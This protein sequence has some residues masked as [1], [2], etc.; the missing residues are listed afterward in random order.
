[1][2]KFPLVLLIFLF[3]KAA[4]GIQ[5]SSNPSLSPSHRPSLRPSSQPSCNPS[6]SPSCEPTPQPTSSPS[7]SPTSQPPSQPSRNPSL[8][9]SS[10][11][12]LSAQQSLSAQPSSQPSSSFLRKSNSL[13]HSNGKPPSPFGFLLTM[14][15][16]GILICCI[17]VLA[18][19]KSLT[20]NK[21]SHEM[22]HHQNDAL[23]DIDKI[24]A[25][26]LVSLFGVQENNDT[27]DGQVCPTR[28]P[29]QD[30]R[31]AVGGGGNQS[32]QDNFDSKLDN[33]DTLDVQEAP[34]QT[35][36]NRKDNNE[37]KRRGGAEE[38][39]DSVRK[40]RHRDRRHDTDSRKDR[41]R[42]SYRH[43]G[44]DQ[45]SHDDL[46]S[47]QHNDDISDAQVPRT[48]TPSQ[49]KRSVVGGGGNQS[50]QVDLE[51]V[52][53]GN[54]DTLDVQESPAPTPARQQDHNKHKRCGRAEEKYGRVREHRRRD[55]RQDD[56]DR[57][58]GDRRRDHSGI[59]C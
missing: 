24:I 16:M 47:V 17:G 34:T 36:P 1:M 57:T 33:D 45:I 8:S 22:K 4:I 21:N 23:E 50:C 32:C 20:G 53:Q 5:P 51:T 26:S 41:G 27:S 25:G 44:S 12:L 14:S 10:Q 7:I 9:P 56:G 48:P 55:R 52:L 28:T 29:P 59:E 31:S 49:D 58:R 35:P 42:D 19:W 30:K 11:L 54:N 3:F 38:K 37:H 2:M 43:D 39:D 40:H 18:V 13:M 15:L 46:N 6:L